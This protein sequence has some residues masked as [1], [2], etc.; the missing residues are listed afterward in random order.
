[1]HRHLHHLFVVLFFCVLGALVA[2]YAPVA[3]LL[4]MV[5]GTLVWAL[6]YR[7]VVG[8]YVLLFLY[9][10]LGWV[11]DFGQYEALRNTALGGVNAPVADFWAVILMAAVV[12]G[13]V[14]N[15]MLERARSAS[16]SIQSIK[17]TGFYR[18]DGHRPS[19]MTVLFFSLFLISAL[20]SLFNLPVGDTLAGVKYI[21]RNM[22]F[23]VVAYVGLPW[24]ILKGEALKNPVSLR[25]RDSSASG[26]GMTA[27]QRCIHVLLAAGGIALLWGIASLFVVPSFWGIWRRVTPFAIGG[28]APLGL[29]HNDLAEVLVAIIPLALFWF[30][31]ER[32]DAWRKLVFLYAALLIVITLLTFSR[33]A[34]VVMFVQAVAFMA[35][36]TRQEWRAVVRAAM[37]FVL[38]LIVPI[39]VYMLVFSSS[40]YV[41]S[42]TSARADL[43]RIAW[44]AFEEHPIIGNGAGTYISLVAQS[45]AFRIEYGPPFD[46]HGVIQKLAAEQGVLGLTTF[47]LFVIWLLYVVFRA[48]RR[49]S[50]G[51]R[52][53]L[54]LALFVIALGAVV[55][56]VFNTQ[57]YTAKMWMPIGFAIA[58]AMIN[59]K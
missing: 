58:V 26:L 13:W 30:Y 39:A 23:T 40:A 47:A 4:V 36:S 42:S 46:A 8:L 5:L 28:F 27:I 51:A 38:V 59:K 22:V 7:P 17:S 53:E 12:V 25:Q 15:V 9:P 57:Y 1:M 24:V 11:I 45:R 35:L 48:L 50:A 18:A 16:D 56:Q 43:A 49:A 29:F 10:F 19:R 2:V 20:I 34:W 55:Y 54:M 41:A 6:S 33:T 3:G 37:P 32:R 31:R 21:L 44:V 52:K 14:R